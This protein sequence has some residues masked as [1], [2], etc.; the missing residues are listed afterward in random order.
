MLNNL[1]LIFD[2]DGTITSPRQMIQNELFR[3]LKK[4]KTKVSIRLLGGG[5]CQ[6]I[7]TQINKIDDVLIYGNYG[8]ETGIGKNRQ[9][10]LINQTPPNIN[11]KQ[12][13]TVIQQIRKIFNLTNYLGD[14]FEIHPSG[15]ITFALLGTKALLNAKLLFDPDKKIRNKI[16]PILQKQLSDYNVMIGGTSSFDIVPKDVN[17]FNTVVKIKQECPHANI[18]YIGD[19]FIDN[20]N[21]SSFLYQHIVPYLTITDQEQTFNLINLFKEYL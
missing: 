10:I 4:L 3:L 13:K 1:I 19:D 15:M 9:L 2:I 20:G 11:L 5:N 14:S 7:Y 6:R 16:L 18:I 8:L 21:D 12:I 17:K